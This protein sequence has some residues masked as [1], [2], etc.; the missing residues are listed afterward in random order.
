M[1]RAKEIP[2]PMVDDSLPESARV[3]GHGTA[4]Y[5]VTLD[6]LQAIETGRKPALDEVRAMDLTVPGLV[7]HE[8][9]T[10][11]GMWMDI[12]AVE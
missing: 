5:A 11:G 8:S 3:G 4:E 2:L 1:E 12:P 9:A 7:A 6:F 10:R